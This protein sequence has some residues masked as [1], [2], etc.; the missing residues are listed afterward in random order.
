MSYFDS[1]WRPTLD[2]HVHNTIYKQVMISYFCKE[3]MAAGNPESLSWRQ[4]GP[5]CGNFRN[6]RGWRGDGGRSSS[7]DGARALHALKKSPITP[8]TFTL[9]KCINYLQ[10]HSAAYYIRKLNCANETR[11]KLIRCFYEASHGIGG[12]EYCNGDTSGF[13]DVTMRSS[14]TFS[15][16]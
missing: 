2:L 1:S 14:H 3:S 15:L 7:R 16:T 13:G 6:A 5:D 9:R 8:V 12:T 4:R 11:R 10:S